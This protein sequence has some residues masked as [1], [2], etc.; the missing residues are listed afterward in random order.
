[1]INLILR[2][3]V[4]FFLTGSF[5]WSIFS[6]DSNSTTTTLNAVNKD[7]K[8][9]GNWKYYGKDLP[10]THYPQNNLV[11]EG[12]YK[13]GKRE[14][15]WIKYHRDGKTPLF[16]GDYVNNKP[17]G[18]F[19]KF[20]D[21]GVLIESGSFV[22]GKYNGFLSRYY[23]NGAIMYRGTFYKGVENGE[24]KHFDKKGNVELAYSSYNG[25]ISGDVIHNETSKS[26]KATSAQ[27][28]RKGSAHEAKSKR[29]LAP[30]VSHPI[31]RIGTFKPDGYNKVYN[32]EGDILQDGIFRNGRLYD[33]KLYQ[34]DS[35]GILFK[36]KV[37]RNGTYVSD[38]QI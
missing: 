23:D 4:S 25:N 16:I 33:G 2:L 8:K 20:N 34:Y 18:A 38:G 27:T 6:Y 17:N 36:V 31:V 5:N 12:Q 10:Q 26:D 19:K 28:R 15:T 30:K 1:M 24:I 29:D 21:G 7:G 13:E 9:T 11:L 14:G 3:L 22:D 35:D 37:Y 32:A